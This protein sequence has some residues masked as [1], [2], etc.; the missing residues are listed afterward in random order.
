MYI[1]KDFFRNSGTSYLELA[2]LVGKDVTTIG[3]KT[4]IKILGATGN[5][6]FIGELNTISLR[7]NTTSQLN[8]A[9]TYLASSP[10]INATINPSPYQT[11]SMNYK[12]NL[13]FYYGLTSVAFTFAT[14]TNLYSAFRIGYVSG[15][16]PL[17]A[18]YQY[19]EITEGT[20]VIARLRGAYNTITST[21]VLYDEINAVEYSLPSNWTVGDEYAVF[22]G[23]TLEEADDLSLIFKGITLEEADDL[24]L[25]FK[26]ITL[27][28]VDKKQ[29]DQLFFAQH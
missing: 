19:V 12:G 11:V 6:A 21:N 26:G 10:A 3:F 13:L 20:T 8:V 23:I 4:R 16:T 25:I 22:R 9:G 29:L 18:K 14:G 24:S 15:T 1:F 5:Q 28:I 7:A 2:S 17:E 27:E